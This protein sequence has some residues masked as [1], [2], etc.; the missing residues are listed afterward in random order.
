MGPRPLVTLLACFALAACS[1]SEPPS[2]NPSPSTPAPSARVSSPSAPLTDLTYPLTGLPAPDRRAA[3][4]TSLAVKIDN[5]L[6]AWPQAG[7]NRAD[8]VFDMQAEGGLTRLMAVYQS[9]PSDL[10]GPIRSARPGDA[11]LLR[12]LNGGYF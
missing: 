9:H 5:V 11:R 10:V 6:G 3:R 2:G 4:R 12:L 1:G 8:I 7:L